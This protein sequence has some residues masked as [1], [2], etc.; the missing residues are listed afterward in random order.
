M[1][2]KE[3]SQY[4]TEN[5]T[6]VARAQHDQRDNKKQENIKEQQNNRKKKTN[7]TASIFNAK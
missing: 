5:K 3:K 1:Q 2:K 6:K 7:K 4:P